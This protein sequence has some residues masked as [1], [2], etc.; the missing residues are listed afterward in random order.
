MFSDKTII[1]SSITAEQHKII[2]LDCGFKSCGTVCACSETKIWIYHVY[3][4]HDTSPWGFLIIKEEVKV[5]EW[6]IL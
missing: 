1:H 5:K 6:S 2:R 4:W 3:H